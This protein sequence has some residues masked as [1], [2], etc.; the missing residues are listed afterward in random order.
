M[1]LL[2]IKSG[3]LLSL[4]IILTVFS[5]CKEEEEMTPAVDDKPTAEETANIRINNWIKDVMDEVYFWLEDMKTPIVNTSDPTSY[6]ESFLFKPT[7]RFSAIYPNYQELISGLSGVSTE[8][9]YEITLLR[10]SN[11]NENV[12]AL[13]TYVKKASPAANENLKRGDL[14]SQINGTTM[15]LANYQSV[16]RQRSSQHSVTFRRANDDGAFGDP[17]TVSLNSIEI[18][19]N[20]NFL[21]TVYTIENQKI[22]Y[23]VYHFF[24]PGV[25][26]SATN[27]IDNRYDAQM[28][29]IFAKFK[30]ENINQ[31]IIDFRYNGGGY[32]SSAVNLA[33]LI[34]PNYTP[35]K[36]FSKTKYNSFLSGFSNF[37]NIQTRFR[38]KSQNIGNQLGDGKIYVLTSSRTASASELIINGLKPYLDVVVIGAKTTG[39]NVG[40]VAL[41][42]EDNPNNSYGLLPIVTKSFNSLDQSDYGTGFIPNEEV[43]EFEFF[44][45]REFGDTR[46]P[47][48]SAAIRRIT[49]SSTSTGR[50][51]REHRIM[52]GS[53]LD[54]KIRNGILLEDNSNFKKYLEN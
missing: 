17:Q 38:D 20:P 44:P 51:K 35:E 40:S 50:L 36:V 27:Q 18:E 1:K 14:I 15:T 28:D 41:E 26:N 30:A 9:G 37:Q 5:S 23:V 12:V 19:E 34:V 52:V 21:D 11:E 6:F 42:D 24:A 45:W 47:L 33:S 3:L 54:A 32:V 31:L 53:S 2:R 4:L 48:L 22:G 8:S 46:D 43:I 25:V 16:L 49:G 10:E 39:K 7:D 29:E 13:I